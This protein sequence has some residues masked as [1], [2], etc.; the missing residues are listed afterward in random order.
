MEREEDANEIVDWKYVSYEKW[1][2]VH[3]L[4]MSLYG[5]DVRVNLVKC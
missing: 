1:N 5:N 3:E 2:C 4:K